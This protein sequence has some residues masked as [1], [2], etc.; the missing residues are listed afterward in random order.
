AVGDR[1]ADGVLQ[2]RVGPGAAEAHVGDR[3][4]AGGVVAGHPVDAAGD[5]G[6]RAGAGAVEHLDRDQVDTLGDA[7]LGA[8]A[9]AGDV[10]AVTMAVGVVTVAD[11]VGAPDGPAAE[12]RVRHANAGVYDVGGHVAG[13]VGVGVAAVQWQV[14]LVDAVQ[15]PGRRVELCRVE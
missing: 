10:G 6:E 1:V 8:A 15:A 2:R 3:G 11:R 14:P 9:G 7:V 12:G 4:D 5:A 13:G